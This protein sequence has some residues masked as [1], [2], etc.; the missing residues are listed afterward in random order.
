MAGVAGAR[1]LVSNAEAVLGAVPLTSVAA[2]QPS[3]LTSPAVDNLAALQTLLNGLPV[4][5]TVLVDGEFYVSGMWTNPRQ[6]ALIGS[7]P[8]SESA[9]RCMPGAGWNGDTFI[10]ANWEDSDWQPGRSAQ[11]TVTNGSNSVGDITTTALNTV[12]GQAVAGPFWTYGS[13]VGVVTPRTG[14]TVLTSKGAASP[15]Y[16]PSGTITQD[17]GEDVSNPVQNHW[18]APNTTPSQ[19]TANIYAWVENIALDTNGQS[20]VTRLG[21]VHPEEKSVLSRLAL[22]DT[23]AVPGTGN[24]GIAL[25]SNTDAAIAGAI[26]IEGCWDYS[27]GDTQA[28]FIDGTNGGKTSKPVSSPPPSI[29]G[30][31]NSIK[32]SNFTNSPVN[33]S[34]SS[35]KCIGVEGLTIDT[36]HFQ[37]VPGTANYL[38]AAPGSTTTAAVGSYPAGQVITVSA[39]V[40]PQMCG[41]FVTSAN[42][43]ANAKVLGYVSPTQLYVSNAA[44]ATG[45]DS[46]TFSSDSALIRLHNCHN[47][48][49]SNYVF[50][51][52]SAAMAQGAGGFVRETYDCLGILANTYTPFDSASITDCAIHVTAAAIAATVPVID[53]WMPQGIGAGNQFATAFPP[54]VGTAVASVGPG[55]YTGFGGAYTYGQLSSSTGVGGEPR[56]RF[57]D[58]R[59]LCYSNGAGTFWTL[60]P[61]AF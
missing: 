29:G 23:A 13:V 56:I 48:A 11:V 51:S 5:S 57:Y 27:H 10:L 2:S 43:P 9:I 3:P 18:Q 46:F 41:L 7:W 19:G 21:W 37:G 53:D 44:S 38:A 30:W 55:S 58:G 16:G 20:G 60:L 61:G 42:L 40:T 54:I 31:G 59:S 15:W 45:A 14:Y 36:A 12:P 6:I 28:I 47:V 25:F 32:I 52:G 49:V 4:G 8:G 26:A 33:C 35:I 39:G 34:D 1:A 24:R 22:L 50:G 17:I